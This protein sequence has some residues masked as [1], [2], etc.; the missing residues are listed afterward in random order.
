MA[1]NSQ[2]IQ[3][4]LGQIDSSIDEL[5][6]L[7]RSYKKQGTSIKGQIE[8]FVFKLANLADTLAVRATV[9][10]RLYWE[11]GISVQ[12][13]ADAFGITPGR[14]KVIVGPLVVQTPCAG[15]C[16]SIFNRTYKN[17][18]EIV[19][20]K[21][22]DRR[23]HRNE[24]YRHNNLLCDSCREKE[25][26]ANA[27][28]ITEIQEEKKERYDILIKLEWEE[29]IST[30]EWRYTRNTILHNSSLLMPGY[31]CEICRKVKC[32]LYLY[33]H[34]ETPQYRIGGYKGADVFFV[35]CK[36]CVPRCADLIIQGRCDVISPELQ[37][38]IADANARS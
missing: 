19:R 21:G 13:M 30:E 26:K 17:R 37:T 38:M 4:L 8:S 5:E 28:R 10:R 27:T 9:L 6:E 34:K 23:A 14:L 2:H 7:E 31:G 12:M 15:N 32:T 24:Y 29:F 20:Y 36:N 33:P 16:G 1:D 25:K 22:Y 11:T 3:H 35:L 18:S